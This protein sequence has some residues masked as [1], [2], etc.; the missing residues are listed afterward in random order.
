[1]L[2]L[3]SCE[4]YVLQNDKKNK[5]KIEYMA[6]ALEGLKMYTQREEHYRPSHISKT[7][8]TRVAWI[9]F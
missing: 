8:G 7:L 1:M 4:I 9:L 5:L 3:K 6:L 2:T